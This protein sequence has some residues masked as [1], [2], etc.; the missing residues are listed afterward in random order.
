MKQFNE[1]WDE[2]CNLPNYCTCS[3]CQLWDEDGSDKSLD[4]SWKTYYEEDEQ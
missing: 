2:S 3:Y 4:P 1:D